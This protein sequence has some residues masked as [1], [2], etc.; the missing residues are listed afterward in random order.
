MAMTTRY[1]CQAPRKLD[2]EPCQNLVRERGAL[3][4]H[5][6][7][8]ISERI[9]TFFWKSLRAAAEVAGAIQLVRWGIEGF[10]EREPDPLHLGWIR[11]NEERARLRNGEKPM[12]RPGFIDELE[13]PIARKLN[14]LDDTSLLELLDLAEAAAAHPDQPQ[15]QLGGQ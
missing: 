11:G 1:R 10:S 2:G 15:P 9:L 6:R 7:S 14:G 3:C 12:Y 8:A 5:H 13:E 4:H